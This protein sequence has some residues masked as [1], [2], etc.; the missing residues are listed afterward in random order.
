MGLEFCEEQGLLHL[1][2]SH[3][4]AVEIGYSLDECY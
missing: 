2:H 3:L 1:K 4:N